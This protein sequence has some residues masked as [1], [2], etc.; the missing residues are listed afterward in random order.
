[1]ANQSNPNPQPGAPVPPPGDAHGSRAAH[2]HE[3]APDHAAASGKGA[4]VGITLVLIAFVA[5]AVYGIWKRHH[6]DEVLAD[7]TQ[8]LAAPSVIL[9]PPQPGAAVDTFILP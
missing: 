7:T 9:I 1:M 4:V 5:L 3:S 8:R 2:D 6:S